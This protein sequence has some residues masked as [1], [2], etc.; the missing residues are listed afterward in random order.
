MEKAKAFFLICAGI[1]MLAA[2]ANMTIDSAQANERE[3]GNII[4]VMP[5]T[6]SPMLMTD[7]GEVWYYSQGMNEWRFHEANPWPGGVPV[8][9]TDWSQL[10]GSYG[11]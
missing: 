4:T 10:K 6:D 8:E 5:Y 1:L 11:K 3:L 7:N 2:A 9:R